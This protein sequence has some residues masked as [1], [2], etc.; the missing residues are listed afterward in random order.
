[1]SIVAVIP[2]RYGSTRFPGKPLAKATGK[3]LVQHVY[4]QVSSCPRIDRVIIATDDQRILNAGREFLAPCLMTSPKHPSGT[5]RIAEVAEGLSAKIIIN[6]Q[7]DEPDIDSAAIEAL[8]GR[9]E[10]EPNTKMATLARKLRPDENPADPNLVNVVLDQQGYALYFSRS[11]IPYGR[12]CPDGLAQNANYLL[13]LGLYAY[14]R[15]F[16]LEFAAMEPSSL[17]KIEKL[18]QLRALQAGVPIAV[19]VVSYHGRGI[20]TPE[21]YADWVATRASQT[22]FA[23]EK[24]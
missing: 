18:E 8:I 19:S 20:D 6:V 24:D 1:M 15:D 3:Y 14:R 5:D 12:D 17:E 7:A 22:S 4:E 2:A 13:H 23:Q 9:L 21:E 16:L 11:V 10:A